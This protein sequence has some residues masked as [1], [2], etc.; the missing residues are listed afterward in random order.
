MEITGIRLL[1]DPVK[2][3]HDEKTTDQTAK[4]EI[5]AENERL[6]E[7]NA[8]S[9]YQDDEYDSYSNIFDNVKT[10]ITDADRDRLIESL[11]Q[12]NEGENIESVVDVEEVIRYFVVHNFVCNYDSY[13]GMI[14]HNYYLYEEDGQMSMIPWDYNL[15]FGGFQAASDASDVINDP[16]DTPVSGE[17]TDSRPML[18]WI[19][20][21]EQY[22]ELYHQYFREFLTEYFDSGYFEELFDA[23]TE[24]IAPYAEEDPTA[25]YTYEE[26]QNGTQTLKEFCLLRAQS[27]EGQLS[28]MIPSDSEGQSEDSSSFVD[29]SGIDLS[30]MGSMSDMTGGG[31][32]NFGDRGSRQTARNQ[33]GE[34]GPD[35]GGLPDVGAI[36]DENGGADIDVSV[37]PDMA[38]TTVQSA[39]TADVIKRTISFAEIKTGRDSI[40]DIFLC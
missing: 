34:N 13:T 25:F 37:P 7:K 24:M 1:T 6:R 36:T 20:S 32:E 18:S 4:T 35:S 30:A 5:C 28:G 15:A 17:T 16:I 31:P 26:F 10:E 39:D 22:T 19:F 9:V 29:A 38:E 11:K 23:V 21:G 2:K 33:D 14:I 12:L 3:R 8:V 40:G 27:I